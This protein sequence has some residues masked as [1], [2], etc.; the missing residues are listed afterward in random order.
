MLALRRRFWGGLVAVGAY[1]CS[2]SA[3]P[4]AP[5][6]SVPLPGHNPFDGRR[7]YVDPN[8]QAAQ[9]VRAN[10]SARPQDAELVRKISE[11]PAAFWFGDWNRNIRADVAGVVRRAGSSLAVLVAYRIPRRDCG[12]GGGA[13]SREEYLSWWT[14]FLEGANQAR[15]VVVFEPDALAHLDCLPADAEE[16]LGL[17]RDAL[18]FAGR[19]SNVS[20]YVDA[21]HPDWQS[22]EEMARRLAAAGAAQ[23]RGFSL[24]VANFV[25]TG[26][27]LAYG[28]AVAA[29]LS[30]RGV[31]GLG[32]IVDTSRN[33]RG[34]YA[35]PDAWCNPPDRSL[36]ERPGLGGG[37]DAF[38]WIKRPGESDG[39]CRGGPPA[40]EFWPEYALGL[41]SRAAW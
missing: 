21:G 38:L 39:T 7:L 22:P 9:W 32:F 23:V 18:A 14:G 33:G 12:L 2:G 28:T 13:G 37:A 3:G 4:A 5:S 40:G 17:I 35:G 30:R 10:A 25:E 34:P 16:R 29:S 31:P 41:V 6:P 1:A 24:N 15:S 8:S 36:G 11:Q 27:C 19:Y 20:I 26:R